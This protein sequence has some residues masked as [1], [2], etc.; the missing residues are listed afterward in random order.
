MRARSGATALR[1]LPQIRLG[2]VPVRLVG[3]AFSGLGDVVGA[4]GD[5]L[6]RD[7]ARRVVGFVVAAVFVLFSLAAIPVLLLVRDR[8]SRRSIAG[9]QEVPGWTWNARA[10]D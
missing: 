4:L 10:V 6:R 7:I 5:H 9:L 3:P 2:P 1:A 8:A